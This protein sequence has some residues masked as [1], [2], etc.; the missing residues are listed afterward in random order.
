LF[1]SDLSVLQDSH[2]KTDQV[3]FRRSDREEEYLL[4]LFCCQVL[5]EWLQLACFDV[6]DLGTYFRV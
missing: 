3:N 4:F 6:E 5:N 2:Q 1:A